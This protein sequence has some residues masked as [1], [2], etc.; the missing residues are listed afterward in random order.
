ME[1]AESMSNLR[2]LNR[3]AP[4]QCPGA[5]RNGGHYD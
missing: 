5:A 4:A 2:E 3:G 1:I